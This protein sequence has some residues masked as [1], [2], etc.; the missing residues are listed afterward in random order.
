LSDYPV[1][2]TIAQGMCT[3]T[4]HA[5]KLHRPRPRTSWIVRPRLLARLDR[6][7]E[8]GQRLI[9]ISA[10]AGAGKTTLLAHWLDASQAHAAWLALDTGDDE[11]NR[12]WTCFFLGIQSV[13][14]G[15]GG[16]ALAALASP[17]PPPIASLLPDL[18]NEIGARGERL[19]VVLDDYH[20]LGNRVIHD[21]VAGLVDRLPEQM[22]LVICTRADPLLPLPRWRARG[23]LTE[24]R[25]ADLR[26]NPE[27]A[28]VFLN[29]RMALDLQPADV[30]QLVAR[31][32]GWAA[33]LQL[34][35]LA[36]Q[37]RPDPHA[38]IRAFA[39]SHH[40]ILDYLIEEVLALQP[41][42]IQIFLL[43]TSILGRMCGPLCD[44]VTGAG[45]GAATLLDLLRQNLFVVPLDEDRWWFRYHHLFAELLRARLSQIAPDSTGT[46]HLRASQWYEQ[47][48]ALVDAVRHALAAQAWNR[49][50]RL[51]EAH[52]QDWWTGSN[53]AMMNLLPDL[54][55]EVVRRGPN[56]TV[57]KAWFLLI[58]GQLQSAAALLT[59]AEALLAAAPAGA[60][61]RALAGFVAMQQAYIAEMLSVPRPQEVDPAEL[62]DIPE[63]RGGMR[64]SAEVILAYVLYRQ[65]NF[66]AAEPLLQATIARDLRTGAT[67]GIP[68]SA[69]RLA[70]MWIAAGH[71][72]EAADLCRRC[73]AAVQERGKWR[74]FVA[75]NLSIV[76]GDVL[77]EWNLLGEAEAHI[78][79]GMEDNEPWQVTHAYA[80]GHTALARLL[81]ARGDHR[82]AQEALD[83]QQ[84][85][86]QGRT[87]P[88]DLAA[89]TRAVQVRIW[90]AEGDLEAV[91][92]WAAAWSHAAAGPG[93]RSEQERLT[94][95]R[96]WLALGRSGEVL[97]LLQ[98]MQQD[99][100][101]GGRTRRLAEIL[102]LAA[103]AW[104]AQGDE[105]NALHA[106][107]QSLALAAPMNC[108]RIYLDEGPATLVLV[109]II[110]RRHAATPQV[111]HFA[112]GI[113]AAFQHEAAIIMAWAP[114][115]NTM[116]QP[117]TAQGR[118]SSSP[119]VEPLT[120]REQ[121]VLTLLASGCSN[122]E[123]AGKLVITLHAVKKHTGNIYGKLGVN[124]RTQAIAR[125]RELQLLA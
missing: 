87:I 51:L 69:S 64:N 31:T 21:G 18:L 70:R 89:E 75:G 6:G 61:H 2:A 96:A 107:E 108:I 47:E 62:A 55:D 13:L 34:A 27:E 91:A 8:D 81:L 73:L 125:A 79:A 24:V 45:D 17:A 99:A 36:L 32:E 35:A 49:A 46:L 57:Y 40:Y 10:P 71:L 121:E 90:L 68:I 63:S 41:A 115:T 83:L 72:Q 123:I 65:G 56:L 3:M 52:E 1:S 100:A 103:A 58:R 33:G 76:L 43:Q 86:T 67:N 44:A 78:R 42:A 80:L 16:D 15:A 85:L 116:P 104:R 5:T 20:V 77:R 38:A 11:P 74:F 19:I 110:N 12:F 30:Q 50:S 105:Q 37:G 102:V 92:Q 82:A 93:F 118:T 54:P 120:A 53:L 23:E 84:Q 124:S 117:G 29:D 88:P 25:D 60:E 4:I 113:M 101:I 94:L 122:Q 9:L 14:P 7:L 59:A 48:G 95:A 26:F 22:R 98:R 97:A 106:L 109:D 119:L 39:G 28:T 66:A 111:Q 112:Q 114:G